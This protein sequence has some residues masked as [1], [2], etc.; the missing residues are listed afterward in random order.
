MNRILAACDEVPDNCGRPGGLP[1]KRVKALVFLLRYSGLRIGDAVMLPVKNVQ[2]SR[3][4][5][6]M[7]KT[8]VLVHLPLPPEVVQSLDQLPRSNPGYFFRTADRRR[9]A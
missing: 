2:D 3:L 8:G 4:L 5:L 1:A 9:T 7:Q 6:Y